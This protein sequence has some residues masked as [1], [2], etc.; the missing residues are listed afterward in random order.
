[1][2]IINIK[3]NLKE[4]RYQQQQNRNKKE[5]IDYSAFF[6]SFLF[7]H[8]CFFIIHLI[9]IIPLLLIII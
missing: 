5:G 2:L 3:S 7:Y 6:V 9:L 4:G 8:F 1:M